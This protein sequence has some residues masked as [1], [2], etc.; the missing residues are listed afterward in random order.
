MA[1]EPGVPDAPKK[2]S[3]VFWIGLVVVVI[4]AL[5]IVGKSAQFFINKTAMSRFHDKLKA[6]DQTPF[7]L[8]SEEGVDQALRNLYTLYDAA[9]ESMPAFKWKSFN[10][11]SRFGKF[12]TSRNIENILSDLQTRKEALY[13]DMK[14]KAADE[15]DLYGYDISEVF[16]TFWQYEHCVIRKLPRLT[17]REREIARAAEQL[18]K[19]SGNLPY[20]K[21]SDI[22]PLA[23]R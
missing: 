5:V 4:V 7:N 15:E 6:Y 12:Y 1:Q 17:R 2:K 8:D 13:R 11:D 20:C 16:Q 23:S 21:R 14:E 10:P 3:F 19:V 22:R 9:A 18:A